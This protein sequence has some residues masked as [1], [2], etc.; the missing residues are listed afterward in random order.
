MMLMMSP[1]I[2]SLAFGMAVE[3]TLNDMLTEMQDAME[4][5]IQVSFRVKAYIR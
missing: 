1:A 2:L 5:Q 4:K 3:D